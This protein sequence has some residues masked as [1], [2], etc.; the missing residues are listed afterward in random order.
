MFSTIAA[1]WSNLVMNVM[2]YTGIT[3][4]FFGTALT[5][6]IVVVSILVL[7]KLIK[8]TYNFIKNMVKETKEVTVPKGK[9]ARAI[10]VEQ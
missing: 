3:S 2:T 5:A 4:T 7:A 1:M 6:I 8:V 10:V 9:A